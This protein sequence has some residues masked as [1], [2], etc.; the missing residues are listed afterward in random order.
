MDFGANKTPIEII[1]EGAFGG[2]YFRD[3]YS[4]VTG[5]W[6]KKSQE[7]FNQ[8]KNFDQKGYCSDY[9]DLNVKKYSVECGTSLRF[10]ENK[11]WTNEIDPYGWFQ[12]YFSYQL[13]RQVGRYIS[14]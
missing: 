2:T 7:E 5:K 12:C 10:W 14:P 6:H 9:Y 3:I 1:K 4:N 11:G 8:L 13:G